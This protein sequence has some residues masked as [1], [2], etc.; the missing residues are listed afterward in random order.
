VSTMRAW[1]ARS[2]REQP[3]QHNGRIAVTGDGMSLDRAASLTVRTSDAP[4]V[5]RVGQLAIR[6]RAGARRM[7]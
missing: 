5:T 1:I 6:R 3:E 2:Q 4:T 7:R